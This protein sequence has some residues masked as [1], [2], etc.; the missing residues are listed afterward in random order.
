MIAKTK[1]KHVIETTNETIK[2]GAT[3]ITQSNLNYIPSWQFKEFENI[4][5]HRHS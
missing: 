1:K 5:T 4:Q 2:L 3:P